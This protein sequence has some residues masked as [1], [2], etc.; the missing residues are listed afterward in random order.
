MAM[1]ANERK[2][3][4]LERDREAL[5]RAPDSIY[6]YLKQPFFQ[7]FNDNYDLESIDQTFQLMGMEMPDFDDDLGPAAHVSKNYMAEQEDIEMLF[8]GSEG[9]IGR[10]EVMVGF[11][12]DAASQLA[13][14]INTFKQAELKAAQAALELQDLSD[15]AAKRAAIAEAVH[16]AKLQEELKKSV[17]WSLPQWQV[18]VQKGR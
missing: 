13:R 3:A 7:Y 14:L 9:S 1:T 8:T 17:R 18:K 5:R 10:A 15:A 6:P 2:R 4:Q 12:L 11:L 16:I